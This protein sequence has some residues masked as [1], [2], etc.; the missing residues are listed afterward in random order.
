MYASAQY[1]LSGLPIVTTPSHGGRDV[2]FEDRF[3]LTVPPHPAAVR[4][5]VEELVRRKLQPEDIHETT[6]AKLRAHRQTFI[7][8]VQDIY[9][10]NGVQR[11]FA[12]EWNRVFRDK[13]TEQR[14][15]LDTIAQLQAADR[16]SAG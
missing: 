16:E 8:L 13:M 1:L 3:V 12:D 10:R 11:R 6:L 5:G 9:R 15:H 14:S 2:F 4:Q 7:A